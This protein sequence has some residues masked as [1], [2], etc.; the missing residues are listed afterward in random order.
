MAARAAQM[1]QE[2]SRLDA[3]PIDQ[4]KFDRVYNDV[5]EGSNSNQSRSPPS[6]EVRFFRFF[7]ISDQILKQDSD[8]D[9]FTMPVRNQ[10]TEETDNKPRFRSRFLDK[11]RGKI[12]DK[13]EKD[14]K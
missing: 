3:A 2:L 12:D 9:E 11:V 1:S 4:D 7:T 13:P 5:L 14:T 10:P 8:N 6:D